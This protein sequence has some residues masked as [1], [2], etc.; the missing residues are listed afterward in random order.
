MFQILHDEGYIFGKQLRPPLKDLC[1]CRILV[2]M[3]F[4]QST[5]NVYITC[6]LTLC[7]CI[8]KNLAR[9][10]NKCTN[11]PFAL[12]STHSSHQRNPRERNGPGEKMFLYCEALLNYLQVIRFG[13]LFCHFVNLVHV[14]IIF[15]YFL[16][17]RS[18]SG[19][20]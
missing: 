17:N 1:T 6:D 9:S 3:M 14:L 10:A 11:L 5:C 20:E 12:D 19:V 2:D 18:N 7:T 15:L 8:V 16:N 4:D 13:C